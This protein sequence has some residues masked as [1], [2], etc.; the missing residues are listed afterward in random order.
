MRYKHNITIL[1]G[2][3]T[4][5]KSWLKRFQRVRRAGCKRQFSIAMALPADA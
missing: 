5:L 4:N 1:S 2:A 3:V